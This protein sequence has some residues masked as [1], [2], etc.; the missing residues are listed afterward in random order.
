[1]KI[2]G[3]VWKYGDEID[4][5]GIYPGKYLVSFDPGEAAQHAMEGIE[6]DFHDK[7]SKGD[8]LVVGN[9]FGS[10]SAREQAAL[11]LKYA[12]VG[13]VIA[14]SFART[15]YRNAINIGLPVI[16]MKGIH[17]LIAEKDEVE[18]DL[19]GGKIR[20]LTQGKEYRFPP[21]DAFIMELL[22]MGGAIPYYKSRIKRQ[23]R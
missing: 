21:I 22:K 16:E 10:G 11:A 17:G 23:D 15:F 19:D 4:T 8:I 9:N 1:M 7:I 3:K 20:N 14:E 18:V 5:D 12:G 2:R 13:A 6:P